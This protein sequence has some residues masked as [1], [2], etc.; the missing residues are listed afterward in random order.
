CDVV[1]ERLRDTAKAL[2][3]NRHD[4]LVVF[5][6]LGTCNAFNVVADQADRAFGLNCDPFVQG[7]EY[8]DLIDDL[9]QL[10]V[11]AEDD[12]LFLK[13]GSELQGDEGVHASGADV[14]VA[15]RRPGVLSA[16]HWTVTDVN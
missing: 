12:V 7:E 2:A 8:L 15:P 13:I 4:G 6:G 9:G 16:T 1:P 5:L 10:F 11:A 14:V 3:T